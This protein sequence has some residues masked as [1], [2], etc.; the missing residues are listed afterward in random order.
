MAK[1]EAAE[2]PKRKHKATYATDKRNGGYLIRIAGPMAEC[3]AGR[4]VPV[5]TKDG[6][7]HVEKLERMIWTG[8]DKES[9]GKVAL[10]KFVS[11]PREAAPDVEF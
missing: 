4:D 2:S 3:F 7:E 1:T 6:S 11:K 5:N 9:G 10:Y 8:L